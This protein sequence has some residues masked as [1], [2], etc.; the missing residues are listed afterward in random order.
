MYR[1][2]S[3]AFLIAPLLLVAWS[4][5]GPLR[6]S[7][8][9]AVVAI[10]GFGYLLARIVRANVATPREWD[11]GSFWLYGHVAAAR[12]NFYEPA[13]VAAFPIPFHPSEDFV[14]SVLEVGFPYPPPTMALFV[15]L[16]FLHDFSLA[17]VLWYAVQFG[18]L[19]LASIVLARAL[20]PGDGPAAALLVV[21]VVLALP[22]TTVNVYDAQTHF[23]ALLFV[24]LA[25]AGRNGRAG[26][27]WQAL[28]VWVKPFAAALFIADIVRSRTQR[29]LIAA[30]V[31]VCS[32]VV[33]AIAFGTAAVSSYVLSNPS[34]REPGSAYFEGVNQSLLAVILRGT[35]QAPDRL[36]IA[37]EPLYLGLSLVLIALTAY[38]CLRA[39][40]GSAFA[41]G[42]ALALG[43]LLYPGTLES[44][45]VALVVP[46]LILWSRRA[47][48]PFGTAGIA[49][50][51]GLVVLLQ[52]FGGF[53]ANAVVWCACAYA[54]LTDRSETEPAYA[55]IETAPST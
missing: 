31:F 4:V 16:G 8:W 30:L 14:R 24:A 6:K 43:L 25:Y 50:F 49:V 1:L 34:Q 35:H 18:A 9:P 21:A 2:A 13:V 15:P 37:H 26:A 51:A 47:R 41:F 5:R 10:A 27:V 55:R 29:L 28:A 40:A 33:A 17:L 19:V 7:P 45:G 11:F 44:Y 32:I 38:L 39:P 52:Q 53:A 20:F 23:V 36:S 22:A 3:V 42:L 54:L 48:L 46:I 12:L